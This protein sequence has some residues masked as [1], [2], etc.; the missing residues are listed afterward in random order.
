MRGY[1]FIVAARILGEALVNFLGMLNVRPVLRRPHPERKRIAFQAYSV[2]LAQCFAPIV[3]KLQQE[4][5]DIDIDFIILPHPHFT[6]RSLW[7]LRKFSRD[8]LN[9]PEKNIRFFWQVLWEKYDLLVCTDVYAR[10][11]L[12][13]RKKVLLKH[14]AGVASRILKRHPFRKT[15]FDFDLVLVNGDADYEI[16]L[17]F[18]ASKFIADSVVVA[19]FPYLDRLHTCPE[20]RAAYLQRVG[21]ASNKKIALLAPSWR[22]LKAIQV[23]QPDYL[24]AI[25]AVLRQLDWQVIIKLH[26]CSFNKA[27]AQGEDWVRRLCCYPRQNVCIDDNIDDVPA[28]LY[29]DLL[30]TDISSRAFDFMLLDKPAIAVFPDGVFTDRLDFERIKLMRQGVFFA[31]S[32]AEIEAIITQTVN[33]H[34]RLPGECQRLARHFFANPGRATEVVVTHLLRHM[35]PGCK[36]Y[37]ANQEQHASTGQLEISGDAYNYRERGR[38]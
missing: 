12:R 26:A 38:R 5:P 27:M 36:I 31:G 23:R 34:G 3:A 1:Q 19:G 32:P 21:L 20:T 14:G 11:P 16:L 8:V 24:D 35:T 10:F 13:S 28:L 22:G 37:P 17:R 9:V 6:F 29:A 25:I 7:E 4:A 18:C 30:V 15:I 33:G 2:H